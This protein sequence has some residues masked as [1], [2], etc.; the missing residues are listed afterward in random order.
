MN[1]VSLATIVV[2]EPDIV[3]MMRVVNNLLLFCISTY[4]KATELVLFHF[5]AVH[6]LDVFV[7]N[8]I[9]L[10]EDLN[11]LKTDFINVNQSVNWCG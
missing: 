9:N 11:N 8:W 3:G 5:Y 6:C 4:K 2:K 7:C 1:D 10:E